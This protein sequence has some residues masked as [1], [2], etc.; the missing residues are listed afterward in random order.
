VC[1]ERSERLECL[2]CVALARP[3]RSTARG[4]GFVFRN[5]RFAGRRDD[6]V[7]TDAA[8][9]MERNKVGAGEW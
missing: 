4:L 9:R 5:H 7:S 3:M 6:F 8:C 1:C 2:A